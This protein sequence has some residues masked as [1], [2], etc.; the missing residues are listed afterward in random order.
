MH[1]EQITR[2]I[3]ATISG[4]DLSQPLDHPAAETIRAALDAHS[5]LVFPGQRLLSD[6]ENL[7][8][9]RHFGPIHIPEFRSPAS[10]RADVT[11]LD[12]DNPK[13]LI[14]VEK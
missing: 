11:I 1:I 2:R 13:V 10:N 6:E 3:G 14:C 7:R 4:I 9:A 12:Q 8:F 5:V